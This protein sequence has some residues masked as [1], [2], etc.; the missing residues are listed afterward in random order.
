MALDGLMMHLLQRE[1]T[2]ELAGG[3]VDKIQQ[4]SR[5]ELVITLRTNNGTKKLLISARAASARVGL[6]TQSIE[7]PAQP[8]MLCMLLR[9]QLSGGRLTAVRQYGMD[10]VLMLDFDCFGEMGDRQTLTVVI[11]IMGRCSNAILTDGNG[12]IIDALKRVDGATSSVRMILPGLNYTLPPMQGKLNLLEEKSAAIVERIV[13]S[14]NIPLHKA[15]LSSLEGASPV[16]CRELAHRACGSIDVM[17]DELTQNQ[18]EQLERQLDSLREVLGEGGQPTMIIDANGRPSD[19]AVMGIEQYGTAMTTQQ[20]ESISDMLDAFAGRREE[21]ERM[22]VKSHDV[23]KVLTN[24]SDRVARRLTAQRKELEQAMDREG[25]R[26]FGDLITANIYRLQ[27]GDAFCELE[28]IFSDGEM[29]RIVLDA[30]LTPAQNAQM[31]YKQYRRAQKA[32]E[33][34]RP[35][36]EQGERELEYI[37][38]VFDMLSRATTNAEVAEIRAELTDEGY[39]KRSGKSQKK[40]PAALPPLKYRSDE[41]FEILVGRN[42][43]QNERLSLRMAEKSDLWLHAAKIP[44]AHVIVKTEG[45]MPPDLTVEQAAIIAATSSSASESGLVAVDYTF[46]KHVTRQPGGKPGMVNYTNQWT[47]YVKPDEALLERLRCK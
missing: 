40:Q 9:K 6:T 33:H 41:G 34:L 18:R 45:D 47:I 26:R 13:Q 1:L 43:R 30:R 38:T 20:Y 36:I 35:L 21:S 25:L 46:A 44:G 15:I 5:E 31:Y 29:V 27:K 16:V 37:D 28:D 12:R 39:M 22:K 17:A 42:N 19:I 3:K 24:A 2:R 10:R 14:G 4:P 11:E 7:N 23:L 8:P 32:E